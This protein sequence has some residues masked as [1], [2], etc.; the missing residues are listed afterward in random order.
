MLKSVLSNLTIILFVF[1]CFIFYVFLD[2][3]KSV[4]Q[5]PGVLYYEPFISNVR[6]EKDNR[7]D[8]PFAYETDANILLKPTNLY[9]TDSS[10]ADAIQSM[11]NDV[12][13]LEQYSHNDNSAN[14]ATEYVQH[15]Q[16]DVMNHPN[17]PYV[18]D[19][20]EISKDLQYFNNASN[21]E[22]ATFQ[23]GKPDNDT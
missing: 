11:Y 4:Y 6:G 5:L 12:S 13:N 7:E 15:L 2:Y 3:L 19:V 16:N 21:L 22:L 1:A 20:Q 14:F 18:F 10:F 23:N 8:G 9:A 17:A